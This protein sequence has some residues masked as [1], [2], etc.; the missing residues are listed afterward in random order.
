MPLVSN[1]PQP[2]DSSSLGL[3]YIF[4]VPS[5]SSVCISVEREVETYHMLYAVGAGL[6]PY[7][8]LRAKGAYLFQLRIQ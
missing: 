7:G 2:R 3:I 5:G 4:L 6:C 1:I 8:R